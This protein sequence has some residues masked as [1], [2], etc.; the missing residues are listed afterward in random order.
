MSVFLYYAGAGCNS[1][2]C[3]CCCHAF[4][5]GPWRSSEGHLLLSLSSLLLTSIEEIFSSTFPSSLTSL[6]NTC[7]CKLFW[8]EMSYPHPHN[9]QCPDALIAPHSELNFPLFC[10]VRMHKDFWGGSEAQ[11]SLSPRLR[12]LLTLQCKPAELPMLSDRWRGGSEGF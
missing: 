3:C 9:S 10:G 1:Q 11:L 8:L 12:T 5:W 7:I 6:C 2:F 4:M